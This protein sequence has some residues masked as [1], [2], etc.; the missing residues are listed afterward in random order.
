MRIKTIRF[1]RER[2]NIT[3]YDRRLSLLKS[4]KPRL[5]V[6]KS[7]S[8]IYAQII[9]YSPDG[10]KVLVSA[11]SADL[12]KAGWK[13]SG[14]NLAASYLIGTLV[15]KKAKAKN[16]KE[17]VL[18][19]GRLNATKGNKIFACLMGAVESGLNVPHSADIFPSK[20]RIEGKHIKP[21]V[22]K[23]FSEMKNKL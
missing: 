3:D 4:G 21:D 2:E 8:S 15:A 9:D 22:Q 5:V 17:A 7:L 18:D 1:R 23:E 6:R 13:H 19:I 10:D 20:D 12:K 14:K 11:S 16:I